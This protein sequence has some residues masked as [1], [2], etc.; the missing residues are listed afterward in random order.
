MNIFFQ[1]IYS[2]FITKKNIIKTIKKKKIDILVYE[3]DELKDILHL[4]TLKNMKV[5]FY[6][7][8]ST[9]DWLYENYTI[10]KSIYKAFS[11]S[12]YVVSIVSFESDYLFKRWGIRSIFMNNFVT[13]EFISVI[14]SDL[15]SNIFI[16]LGRAKAK[17]KKIC[18]WNTIYGIYN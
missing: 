1:V 5:I 12:K 6:H 14:Q 8:S 15:S 4:N 10:F 18:D 7:H 3:L 13:Y 11:F 17:K 9:F 16:M 2:E